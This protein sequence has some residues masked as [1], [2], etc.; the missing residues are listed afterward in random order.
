MSNID[1]SVLDQMFDRLPISYIGNFINELYEKWNSVKRSPEKKEFL[2]ALREYFKACG[3]Y[4]KNYKQISD[5]KYYCRTLVQFEDKFTEAASKIEDDNTKQRLLEE[6]A[7]LLEIEISL[8][9]VEDSKYG[10]VWFD[11]NETDLYKQASHYVPA[12]NIMVYVYNKKYETLPLAKHVAIH[13]TAHA[14]VRCWDNPLIDDSMYRDDTYEFRSEDCKKHAASHCRE[15]KRC[16]LY[17]LFDFG[18]INNRNVA[19]LGNY[20]KNNISKITV[21]DELEEMIDS[22][23]PIEPY[24]FEFDILE[25]RI[26]SKVGDVYNTLEEEYLEDSLFF[27]EDLT[28]QQ[29]RR[30]FTEKSAYAAILKSMGIDVCETT[31]PKKF[32]SDS[33]PVYKLFYNLTSLQFHK[34]GPLSQ[35]YT[36]K[37]LWQLD[38]VPGYPSLQSDLLDICP[39]GITRDSE[40]TLLEYNLFD[41]L[42][43][44]NILKMFIKQVLGMDTMSKIGLEDGVFESH[45]AFPTNLSK[46][47]TTVEEFFPY[48]SIRGKE[49][50]DYFD[51]YLKVYQSMST[52]DIDPMSVST[53]QYRHIR[54]VCD[55]YLADFG[56]EIGT[57]TEWILQLRLYNKLHLDGFDDRCLNLPIV[58]LP[59]LHYFD[60]YKEYGDMP[61]TWSRGIEGHLFYDGYSFNGQVIPLECVD[62]RALDIDFERYDAA[63]F[64]TFPN[65]R[66]RYLENKQSIQESSVYDILRT[67]SESELPILNTDLTVGDI[68]GDRHLSLDI[69]NVGSLPNHS[70]I[71]LLE[72]EE[73]NKFRPLA[74]YLEG[75]SYTNLL[76]LIYQNYKM[77]SEN[78]EL[79]GGWLLNADQISELAM[80]ENA[81]LDIPVYFSGE[82]DVDQEDA[83]IEDFK[84]ATSEVW[85]LEYP[86]LDSLNLSRYVA[87]KASYKNL[88]SKYLKS[89]LPLLTL[90]TN[91]R[92]QNSYSDDY[93]RCVFSNGEDI[94]LFDN[95]EIQLI[96][97]SKLHLRT[98]YEA[99]NSGDLKPIASIKEA[100]ENFQ[101]DVSPSN[102]L[103]IEDYLDCEVFTYGSQ[104][105][106]NLLEIPKVYGYA[107]VY[108]VLNNLEIQPKIKLKNLMYRGANQ[109][110]A[111]LKS[112]REVGYV[113]SNGFGEYVEIPYSEAWFRIYLSES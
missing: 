102:I 72:N 82:G 28:S 29:D 96:R 83:P 95:I 11:P 10:F 8:A 81:E 105:H 61:S 13:E 87:S 34:E 14:A 17:L 33:S 92:K 15:F 22:Y 12:K 80:S 73:H 50:L 113:Y 67:N 101:L 79:S 9:R 68:L 98:I 30:S 60:Y 38:D 106:V 46:P 109:L 76:P 25:P 69:P 99:I 57:S 66:T 35:V 18:L 31:S 49:F 20:K 54:K 111:F 6:I 62:E 3:D 48:A 85:S 88:L 64:S 93:L 112:P 56:L 27:E 89:G 104:M 71:G 42:A 58:D 100:R 1:M 107:T 4:K 19:T 77:L 52:L 90:L 78:S 37:M 44:E 84:F 91:N 53:S 16:L 41:E 59:K 110:F 39:S 74:L 75:V 47:H 70:A 23:F 40:E 21:F 86:R 36:A 94:Y 26:R 32:F 103:D 45:N 7:I 2:D 97:D 43:Q 5:M 108:E 63:R 65:A 24:T 51:T 55:E